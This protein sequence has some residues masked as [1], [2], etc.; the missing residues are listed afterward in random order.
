M[1]QRLCTLEEAEAQY[2]EMLRKARPDLA[3]QVYC[4]QKKESRPQKKEWRPKPTKADGTASAGINMVF[5]L[6]P[7]FYAPDRKELPVAQLDFGPRPVIFQ[8]PWEKNYEH[9]K[10]PY[11]KGYINGHPVNK[12][13]V[14]TGAAVN[15][16]PYSVLR[17]LGCSAEDL[18]KTNVTLSDFN[19]QASEAQGVLNV[20]LTVGSKTVPTSFFIVNSKSTYTV[21]L[22][23]DWIHANCCIP[24]M[25]HQCLIQW[26]GDEVEV[27]HADDSIKISL[28][29]MSVCDAE[30]QELI[31]GISLEGCGHVEA[32]KN[33][34]RLVLST[35]LTE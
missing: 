7:E 26:D 19:G 9:L 5:V 13:L 17:R 14:D 10:A 22:R 11:L 3:V 25:M 30:D 24:S 21:L 16:M 2:L 23:R 8:K 27:V 33:G 32:T 31:S 29:A 4:T 20:D 6:P 28:A 18:I 12:M 15:I 34:V 35:G 1:I